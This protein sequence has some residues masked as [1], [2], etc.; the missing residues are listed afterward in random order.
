M[1][2]YR[3]E[4]FGPNTSTELAAGM[5]GL[6]FALKHYEDQGETIKGGR[7]DIK[8]EELVF[9]WEKERPGDFFESVIAFL[10][11]TIQDSGTPSGLLEWAPLLKQP[12]EH[13]LWFQRA[14]ENTLH[15]HSRHDRKCRSES[16]ALYS[17][18]ELLERGLKKSQNRTWKVFEELPA[19][20]KVIAAF[21][22]SLSYQQDLLTWQEGERAYLTPLEAENAERERAGKRP[23]KIK[24]YK[25]FKSEHLHWSDAQGYS[26]S[27]V[28]NCTRLYAP[29]KGDSKNVVRANAFEALAY[30]FVALGTYPFVVAPNH[31]AL[32]VPVVTNLPE[33]IVVRRNAVSNPNR[34]NYRAKTA[35]DAALRVALV[36][37]ESGRAWNL[38][39]YTALYLSGGNKMIRAE[40]LR[41]DGHDKNDLVERYRSVKDLSDRLRSLVARD[42]VAGRRLYQQVGEHVVCRGGVFAVREDR[43]PKEKARAIA[44][45]N[46]DSE[47]RMM[48][49]AVGREMTEEEQVLRD[50]VSTC[51]RRGYGRGHGKGKDAASKKAYA[52][53][54][55]DAMYRQ[56]QRAASKQSFVRAMADIANGNSILPVT[57]QGI[58]W[59]FLN[60]D[61]KRAKSLAVF[62]FAFYQPKKDG[63]GEGAEE[64]AEPIEEVEA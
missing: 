21:R 58:L 60:S 19:K 33:F 61:W 17:D 36:Q 10:Q 59:K 53:E 27:L 62:C 15:T 1:N 9:R 6:A 47:R 18:E 43:T 52:K 3:L 20:S 11:Y 13:R 32:V 25:R 42:I 23:K 57:E 22:S 29:I 2:E 12:L 49:E 28:P 4:V 7:I 39:A 30:L 34:I 16:R 55:R 41:H 54:N 44:G 51:I 24:P 26:S 14:L 63:G 56:I 40:S 37:E 8:D 48:M 50:Y 5:G 64:I 46:K 45:K 35:E 38:P 31:G